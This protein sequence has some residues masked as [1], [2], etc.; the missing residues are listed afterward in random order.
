MQLNP[1][2]LPQKS[3]EEI[4]RYLLTSRIFHF[5]GRGHSN[6][7]EPSQSSLLL[8]DWQESPLTVADLR[9]QRLQENSPFLGYLSAC[10]T[11]TNNAEQLA[12]EAI[13]LVSA[14]QLASFRH[15]IGTL[16]AVSDSHCVDVAVTL[17]ETLRDEG[18]TDEAVYRG[19]HLA[20]RALRDNN[21]DLE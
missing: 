2:E 20:L 5:A 17:Y 7:V 14:F 16:W 1:V 12:D 10:S 19:L 18:M 21:R 15:V 6:P 13:H 8:S 11:G 9:D 4:I 3:R